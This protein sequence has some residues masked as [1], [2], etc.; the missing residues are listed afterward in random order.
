MVFKD[1]ADQLDDFQD[2]IDAVRNSMDNH[3][4][5]AVAK[6]ADEFKNDVRR[7]I[8]RKD[9]YESGELLRS[10]KVRKVSDGVYMVYSNAEHAPYVE[11]GRGPVEAE[12]GEYLKFTDE[13]GNVIFRKRVDAAEEQPFWEPNE[14]RYRVEGVLEDNFEEV[15][16]DELRR[17]FI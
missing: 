16:E 17:A 7:T 15:L 6:T 14:T 13:N 2:S 9:L 1:F 11:F 3:A 8:V 10:I 12:E 4:D 5:D